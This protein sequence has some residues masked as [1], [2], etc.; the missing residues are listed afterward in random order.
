MKPQLRSSLL[1]LTLWI[2]LDTTTATDF[3][4]L[5]TAIQ[6]A[7]GTAKAFKTTASVG[8]KSHDVYYSKGASGKAEKLAVI[9]KGI[10]EPNCT[11]TWVITVDAKSSK[12]EQV[13]VVEMSCP[14][15]FPAQ[16]AA[17]LAQYKGVGPAAVKTLR[18]E[19]KTIAKATGS[20]N[21]TTDAVVV[22]IGAAE[23]L[24]GKI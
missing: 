6:N 4:K 5:G 20:C 24:K 9:Q 10:Y 18:D 12:V 22:A 1:I 21:L 19:V 17:Y 15:A 11:H 13:R 7:L 3:E 23:N 14:H 8:K 16:K 2:A